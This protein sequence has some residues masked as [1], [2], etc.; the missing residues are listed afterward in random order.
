LVDCCV[1]T[2]VSPWATGS[3]IALDIGVDSH[4]LDKTNSSQ[5]AMQEIMGK[6]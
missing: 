6:N 1:V 3:H 4:A 5:T 2:M